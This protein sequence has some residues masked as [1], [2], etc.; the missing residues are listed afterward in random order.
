[1]LNETLHTLYFQMFIVRL[2]RNNY[3]SKVYSENLNPEIVK[4]IEYLYLYAVHC[5]FLIVRF[6]I[7]KKKTYYYVAKTKTS[8]IIYLGIRFCIN[9]IDLT[10]N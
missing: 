3:T 9:F 1:M 5:V 4:K 8:L 10:I 2:D 6:K 7:W